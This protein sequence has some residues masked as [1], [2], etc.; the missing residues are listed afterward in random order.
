MV[1]D[2]YITIDNKAVWWKVSIEAERRKISM[3][4]IRT[5]ITLALIVIPITACVQTKQERLM[6]MTHEMLE[7][8]AQ[9]LKD[10]SPG[11]SAV[12]IY[13]KNRMAYKRS[14]KPHKYG[15]TIPCVKRAGCEPHSF[16][17]TNF[18]V[19]Q[20]FL[21]ESTNP[22]GE[23]FSPKRR[24]KPLPMEVTIFS[25]GL[26]VGQIE[27]R[28]FKAEIVAED[29]GADLALVRIDKSAGIIDRV[30]ILAPK[31]FMPL[32]NDTAWVAGAASKLAPFLRQGIFGTSYKPNEFPNTNNVPIIMTTAEVFFGDSGGALFHFS[33]ERNRYEAV[34]IS[35]AF[36]RAP[37]LASSI[38]IQG[39]Y[40]FLEK[41]SY[42]FIIQKHNP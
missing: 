13:S 35:E 28:T 29:K 17:L 10:G 31:G 6:K 38:S 16:A 26:E 15:N 18:H 24:D 9:I 8:V 33:D 3:R 21:Y 7:P 25:F 20:Q 34:G 39:V 19:A 27:K 22:F 2:Q 30:A 1:E 12:V 32:R 36:Y 11:A 42:N 23:T 4:I 40:E 37:F 5:L 14:K 41:N